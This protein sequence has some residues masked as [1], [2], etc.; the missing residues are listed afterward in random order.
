MPIVTAE[1]KAVKTDDTYQTLEIKYGFSDSKLPKLPKGIA[2]QPLLVKLPNGFLSGVDALT[3]QERT[4]IE[5]SEK[6]GAAPATPP[7]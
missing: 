4:S 6:D 2:L 1:G 3:Q 7:K 5:A